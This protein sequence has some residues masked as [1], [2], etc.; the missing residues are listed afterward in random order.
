MGARRGR[1]RTA[2]GRKGRKEAPDYYARSE[3]DRE[4]IERAHQRAVAK[5]RRRMWARLAALAV[6]AL[7][8][9]FLGPTIYHLIVAEG[10]QTAQEFKGVGKHIREGVERRS[11][12]EFE[13]NP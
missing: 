9:Y 1:A 8:A 4:F 13:E 7:I 5:A 12:A 2:P 6:L 10:Q 3:G 11:G